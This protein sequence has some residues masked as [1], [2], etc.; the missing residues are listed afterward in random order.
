[1]TSEERKD[2]LEDTQQLANYTITLSGVGGWRLGLKKAMPLAPSGPGK[3]GISILAAHRQTFPKASACTSSTMASCAG[4]RRWCAS[5]GTATAT[6]SCVRVARSRS[7]LL[8]RYRA[9]AGFVI[10][11]GN[12]RT[13]DLFLN[14]KYRKESQ[15][16]KETK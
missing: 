5:K 8:S 1:M 14:G 10:A 11:G 7:R 9:F 16:R 3:N 6:R 2:L 12:T 15:N 13:N 4:M